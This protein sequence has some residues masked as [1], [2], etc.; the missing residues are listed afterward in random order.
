MLRVALVTGEPG[1]KKGIDC[2]LDALTPNSRRR[3]RSMSR[4]AACHP[5]RLIPG[6]CGLTVVGLA[7]ALAYAR[8]R[9]MLAALL[10]GAGMR[11]DRAVRTSPAAALSTNGRMRG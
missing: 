9:P 4:H 5:K 2:G 8:V 10:W 3:A 1:A 7:A 11:A 6:Q